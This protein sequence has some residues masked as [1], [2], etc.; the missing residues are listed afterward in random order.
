ANRNGLVYEQK[1]ITIKSEPKLAI[2]TSAKPEQKS[3]NSA[4]ITAEIDSIVKKLEE[5][6]Y[7]VTPDKLGRFKPVLKEQVMK[8]FNNEQEV[9][10]AIDE[11]FKDIK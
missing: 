3:K 6:N 9:D 7:I 1:D 2:E 11:Y 10:A 8:K 5:K 4:E